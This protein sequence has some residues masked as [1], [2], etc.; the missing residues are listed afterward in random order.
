M[1]RR[2]LLVVA[3]F[4]LIQSL[5]FSQTFRGGVSG[6]VVDQSGAAVADAQVKLVSVD[7]GLTRN[8]AATNSG[9]FT[10]QDLPL[11]AYTLT[12]TQKGFQPQEIKGIN[13]EA[14]RVFDLKATLSVATQ[15][16]M[17][18]VQ[19]EAVAI[20]TSSTALTSVIPTKALLDIPLNG[21]DFTQLLKL[22]PASPLPDPLTAPAP[23]PLTG[24]LTV[25]TI[26]INGTIPPPLTKAAFLELPV[27]SCPLT[28]LMSSHFR[29]TVTP[30][31][32]AM[33]AER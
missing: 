12:V 16:S 33:L 24:R 13:V 28:Q 8:V 2:S 1:L 17:V 15:T 9:E 31:R 11:G 21:R 4:L 32:G 29:R 27:P 22:N 6:T 25:P 20:E 5:G 26:T 3:V 10:F 14:G 30:S 19:A 18:E 7:T 23:I